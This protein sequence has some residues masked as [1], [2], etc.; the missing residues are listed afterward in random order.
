MFSSA[1]QYCLGDEGFFLQGT[2]VSLPFTKTNL[3]TFPFEYN[4]LQ[5]DN[6]TFD[7]H[8]IKNLGMEAIR[9]DPRKV[10]PITWLKSHS[11]ALEAPFIT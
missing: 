11:V 2:G 8:C 7:I 6:Q 1:S 3:I 9:F 4:I 5:P 10:A